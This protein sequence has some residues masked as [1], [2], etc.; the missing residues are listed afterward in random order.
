M[1]T[2]YAFWILGVVAPLLFHPAS[3]T[4]GYINYIEFLTS[5][6]P[7]E[8]YLNLFYFWWVNL[9]YVSFLFFTLFLFAL[10]KLRGLPRLFL[11]VGVAFYLIWLSELA[12]FLGSNTQLISVSTLVPTVNSLLLNALNKY[13]P[14]IFYTS[15]VLYLRICWYHSLSLNTSSLFEIGLSSRISTT[16][17]FTAVL[18][19]LFA[20]FLGSW[21]ALQEGTWGGWWNWDSSETFGLLPSLF[22]LLIAHSK[23]TPVD[24]WRGG[25]ALQVGTFV[26]IFFYSVLQLN[27]D[28]IS[29][30]FGARFFHFFN[31][32]LVFILL[33]ILSLWA[34]FVK[35]ANLYAPKSELQ[36][37]TSH[38]GIHPTGSTFRRYSSLTVYLSLAGWVLYSFFDFIEATD[39]TL[40]APIFAT[41]RLS[42]Y[43]LNTFVFIPLAL[44]FLLT[45][46]RASHP[47]WA[48]ASLLSPLTSPL[49]STFSH[50][51]RGRT[52]RF[53]NIL[54]YFTFTCLLTNVGTLKSWC[55]SSHL[56]LLG[57]RSGG[58]SPS[59]PLHTCDSWGVEVSRNSLGDFYPSVTSWSRWDSAN[60]PHT[61]Q[62][63]LVA[64]GSTA[65]STLLVDASYLTS[66]VL[67]EVTWASPML[68]LTLSL[69]YL[70][71]DYGLRRV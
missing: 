46:S 40:L 68:I 63:A 3:S 71:W 9:T 32:N 41:G 60:S 31:S 37:L 23:I 10:V 12:D 22:L 65:Q 34:I 19:N 20:L 24:S 14:L 56:Y 51:L 18:W 43:D 42:F 39:Y 36:T 25:T 27:F 29:H 8:P 69:F 28:L 55:P 62:L 66:S 13:H 70:Y 33:L 47:I 58:G 53:H 6:I 52:G 21:W 54:I 11:V 57:G 49:L 45:R 44:Y 17:I 64:N 15:I 2:L 1:R 67:V 50:S 61:D 38:I 7:N 35:I 16:L 4:T 5:T 30:N 59:A 48:L 26:L